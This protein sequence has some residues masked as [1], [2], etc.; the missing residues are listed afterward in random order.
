MITITLH[1]DY[2]HSAIRFYLLTGQP[3]SCLLQQHSHEIPTVTLGEDQFQMVLVQLGAW[4]ISFDAR[5]SKTRDLVFTS[6][7]VSP[8]MDWQTPG[9]NLQKE[10]QTPGSVRTIFELKDNTVN[11][12]ASSKQL[13]PDLKG[14]SDGKP[15]KVNN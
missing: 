7:V 13:W 4:D 14:L 12:K 3:V 15:V 10:W 5:A 11:L 9:R 2:E 8:K 6:F 1:Y